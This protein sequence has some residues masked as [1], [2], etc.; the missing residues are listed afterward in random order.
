M[1]IIFFLDEPFVGID[2]ISEEL[3]VGLLQKLK[4]EGKT[5]LI[6]HHDLSKVKTYFD[7]VLLLNK[8]SPCLRSDRNCFY[9]EKSD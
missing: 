1:L 9:T 4:K 8:K 6:I 3:I 2:I 5:I 7:H